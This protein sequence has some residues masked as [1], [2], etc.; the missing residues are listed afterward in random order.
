MPRC[1]HLSVSESSALDK[2]RNTWSL[3][4]LVEEFEATLLPGATEEAG[5]PPLPFEIHVYWA[6]DEKDFGKDFEMRVFW[7][8][9]GDK[10]RAEKKF[11]LKSDSARHRVRIKG[12]PVLAKGRGDLRVEWRK[13]GAKRWTAE[14][15]FWPMTVTIVTAE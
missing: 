5:E 2:Y 7:E 1:Y 3:F 6:F 10:V 13:E 15:A 4:N 9:G 14:E 8:A 11:R 12:F